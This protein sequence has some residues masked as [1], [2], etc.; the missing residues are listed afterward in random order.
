MLL[1]FILLEDDR[2]DA[3]LVKSILVAE[4]IEFDLKLAQTRAD[5]LAALEEGADLVLADY[6]LP[7]F[8]GMSALSILRERHPEV[9]FI[10]V[11]GTLGEEVAVES[12][13]K[14]ATDYVLKQRLSRLV[15]SVRR[16]LHEAE[17]HLQRKRAEEDLQRSQERLLQAQ[18]IGNMGSWEWDVRSGEVIWS[19][20]VYR[21]FGRDPRDF[22]PSWDSFMSCVHP[23][24]RTL[25]EQWIHKSM[26]VNKSFSLE[27]RILRPDDPTLRYL[28]S[29]GEAVTDGEGRPIRMTGILVDITERNEAEV[30]LRQSEEQ[31]R[32][33]QKMEAIGR[34][35]GGVAHEFKNLLTVIIGYSDLV[36]ERFSED[37]PVRKDIEEIKKAGERAALL[38]RQLL[39]FSRKQ[40]LQLRVLD[41][42]EVITDTEKMLQRLIGEDIQL[43]VRPAAGLG[44]VKADP[45]QI[46][47]VIM[48]LVVNACDAMPEGGTLTIETANVDLDPAYARRHFAVEP[49]PYVMLAV[50]D[51]GCGMDAATQARIFEPFFT[52]KEAGKGTGLGLSTIYGI[53]KQCDGNIWVYSEPGRGSSF[54]VYLQR[55]EESVSSVEVDD[56][57]PQTMQGSE[58]ILLVEDEASIRTLARSVLEEQGYTVLEAGNG[59]E[60]IEVSQRHQGPIHLLISD[61]VMPRTNT[62]EF[63]QRMTALRPDM[64]VLYIS[65]YTRETIVQHGVLEEGINFIE[66][67]FT[68]RALLTK[69]RQVL[70]GSTGD[71]AAC[72]RQART[73]RR[74]FSELQGRCLGR[75]TCSQQGASAVKDAPFHAFFDNLGSRFH[76]FFDNLGSRRENDDR[77]NPLR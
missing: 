25:F 16:A 51:T 72:S 61:V 35:A 17:E 67:P 69:V 64:K 40:V 77:Q 28:F 60:G 44:Q 13:K 15:P 26:P 33:S 43:V 5:F 39:A 37:D 73:D 52:T 20:Q 30:A 59:V 2:R 76:A 54:K 21:I 4:G 56:S 42:N 18:R 10:F 24:D 31:L 45:G 34:L 55:V 57:M 14:G 12:L 71:S 53:V 68:P 46:Q 49:G 11:T 41:L 1:R 29:Q 48:N 74:S 38:T 65:G 8:D 70:D 32:Q 23:E 9:P 66:K 7:S 19:E 22:H 62:R 75:Q 50:S 63:M 27:F 47:Q 3:E 36:L 58:T 6:S